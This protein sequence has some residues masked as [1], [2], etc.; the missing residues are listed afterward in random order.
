MKETTKRPV[1]LY[2]VLGVLAVLLLVLSFYHKLTWTICS[3][4][5]APTLKLDTSETWDGGATYSHWAYAEDSDAQYFDL[6][7]P[8]ADAPAPLF[9]LV[10]GGGFVSGDSQTRQA[11]FMYRYFRDHGFACASINYRL[12]A[13]APFPAACA[14]VKAAVRYLCRNAE[15][16]GF[17]ATRIAIWGE[18]AGGYLATFTALTA[19]DA[20]ADVLCIGESET[21]RFAMPAF[22]AL[23]DY[24]GVLDFNTFDEDFA[25]EGIPAWVIKM[26]NGWTNNVTGAFDSFEEY[27]LRKAQKDWTDFE[28]NDANV[29]YHAEHCENGNPALKTLIVHGTADITVSHLQS[30][31]LERILK[32]NGADVTLKL[33]NGC[34]HADDRLFT[35]ELLGEVEAFVNASFR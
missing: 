30:V 12:A 18:S 21:E 28:R 3:N 35:N 27:W 2:I 19:P 6:Y 23:V 8:H 4:L 7:V 1:W 13:E 10:H 31:S 5:F 34:K 9:V 11:Q 24:Y 20:Y 29:L 33:V 17:D 15:T 25:A 22:D 14:D 26:A 32:A 16:F